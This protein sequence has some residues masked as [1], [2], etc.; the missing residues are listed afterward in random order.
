[1]KKKGN[2]VL[3]SH[4]YNLINILLNSWWMDTSIIIH[5]VNSIHDFLTC[6]EATEYKKII[7]VRNKMCSHMKSVIIYRILLKLRYINLY[8]T[9]YV[10]SYNVLFLFQDLINKVI[11]FKLKT[12]NYPCLKI[13]WWLVLHIYLELHTNLRPILQYK[14]L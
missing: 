2:L 3:V 10:S 4:E 5:V 9:F 8:D 13:L 7:F 12:F 1:M 11:I 6:W 14:N